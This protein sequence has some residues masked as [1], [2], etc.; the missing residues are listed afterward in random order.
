VLKGLRFYIWSLICVTSLPVYA[1]EEVSL[2][3]RWYH[4][5]QFAGYYMALERGFYE[6]VGIDVEIIEGGPEAISPTQ[7]MLAGEADFAVT[8]SG[9]AVHRLEG[10]PVV[11]TAAIMQSSPEV[12]LT[13]A[14]NNISTPHDLIAKNVAVL[15]PPESAELLMLF[16][17][18]G[19]EV[20]KVNIVDHVF[21]LQQL[22][23]GN[24]DA[25]EAY[26]SNEP[27]YLAKQGIAYN[28]I[29]PRTYG[30]NFYG[31]VLA[32][33]EKFAVKNPKLVAEFT[34][35]S[36]QGWYYALANIE[37]TIALIHKKYAPEKSLDHL[38]FE[39]EQI[40]KLIFAD[41]VEIGHMNPGRWQ[42]IANSYYS[43]GMAKENYGLDGF[44]FEYTTEKDY[45]LAFYVSL[46][47]IIAISSILYVTLRLANLSKR[48]QMANDQ[49]KVAAKETAEANDAK[50]RFLANMSHEIR[51][52]L[53]TI[54][55]YADG[56]LNR[57]ISED[58][59]RNAL[60]NIADSGHHLLGLINDV[61]DFSKIEAGELDINTIDVNLPNLLLEVLE[62]AQGLIK[63][64]P[65]QIQVVLTQPIP[66][67]IHTDPVRVRQILINLLSNAIKFTSV[68]HIKILVSVN[69]QLLE[70]SVVDTGIGI[71]KEGIESLFDAFKQHDYSTTREYG[72][73]GLGLSISRN[74]ANKLGGNLSA[75]SVLGKGST[76]TFTILMDVDDEVE[77]ITELPE[78]KYE[79]EIVSDQ[80]LVSGNVLLAEDHRENR[81]LI[82]LVL[83]N[84]GLTVETTENGQDAVELCLM[85]NYNLVLLDIQMP[86]MDGMEAIRLIK[87]AGV[88]TPII[89]VTA[90]VFAHDIENYRKLGFSDC[91]AKPIDRKKLIKV[92]NRHLEVDVEDSH[93]EFDFGE[94]Q[95]QFATSFSS[96]VT[97]INKSLSEGDYVRLSK[98]VHKLKGSAPTFG[99]TEIGDQASLVDI[100][101][102]DK[103]YQQAHL[104]AEQLLAMLSQA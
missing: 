8:S 59:Q 1:L 75:T 32:T 95:R 24:V 64:K 92:I 20:S 17:E 5:F 31:D 9:I 13:L 104:Q 21:D 79:D 4:Q 82:K 51:T 101:L 96:Y 3:L 39:A 88:S 80:T 55:G 97:E 84:L 73:T 29:E 94:L 2:Q 56:V 52:P 76:F 22:I 43:L 34:K 46:F 86:V 70:F 14:E 60:M 45:S 41:L 44:I 85:N 81:E 6:R 26:I 33:S 66:I 89:A 18:E 61:L 65:I 30:V 10:K 102:K 74:L 90:N 68:G 98:S 72:G 91:I 62:I 42:Y 49:L 36:I 19:L 83:E 93:E 54:I 28:I 57:D 25:Y 67:L 11:V 58:K 12:L 78:E 77:W 48:L 99:F 50:S 16:K 103:D 63:G 69:E 7:N 87:G 71:K 37:E 47:S 38:R 15:P 23:N 100:K 40:E 27:Y 35:A 53:T